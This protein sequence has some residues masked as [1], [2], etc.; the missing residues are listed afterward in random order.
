MTRIVLL[1]V[2]LSAVA[3][4]QPVSPLFELP[5]PTGKLLIGTT[6]WVVTDASR[7]E[8]FAPGRKR[9]IEIIAWYPAGASGASGASGA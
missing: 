1:L 2:S 3:S 7:D 4:A 9:D 8:T 5:A 6:R